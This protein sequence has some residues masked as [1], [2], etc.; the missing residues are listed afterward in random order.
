M[1]CSRF[2]G[3]GGIG[4]YV[5]VFGLVCILEKN[6]GILRGGLWVRDLCVLD[7]CGGVGLEMLIWNFFCWG[8]LVFWCLVVTLG[9]GEREGFSSLV[10]VEYQC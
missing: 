6:Q 8:G 2:C 4:E 10:L 1:I 9:V 3:L 7:C 5:T